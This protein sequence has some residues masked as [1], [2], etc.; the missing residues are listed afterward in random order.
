MSIFKEC[1]SMHACYGSL[2][3]ATKTFTTITELFIAF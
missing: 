1:V 3:S 2:L